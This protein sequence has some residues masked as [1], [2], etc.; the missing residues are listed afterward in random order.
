MTL[1]T[2][3]RPQLQRMARQLRLQQ[4]KV[5]KAVSRSNLYRQKRNVNKR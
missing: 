2:L 4:Q 1:L 5:P 3:T